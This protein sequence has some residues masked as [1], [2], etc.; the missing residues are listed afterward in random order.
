MCSHVGIKTVSKP[1][2]D[3]VSE[4]WS[5][6]GSKNSLLAFLKCMDRSVLAFLKCIDR[7]VLVSLKCIDGFVLANLMFSIKSVP[8]KFP[9]SGKF[10]CT[11]AIMQEKHQNVLYEIE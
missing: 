8:T 3:I 11:I 4:V 7:S 10:R 9:Q 2:S 6:T 5:K 1:G